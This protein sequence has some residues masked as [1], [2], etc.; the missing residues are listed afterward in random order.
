MNLDEFDK[1]I[2]AAL[3][4]DGGF[5]VRDIAKKV[6]RRASALNN[7]QHSAQINYRLVQM[8]HAGLVRPLF[9][10]A[11]VVWIKA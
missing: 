1:L 7:R 9:N 5:L 4:T 10:D 8:Q 3:D 11:P 2:L 6:P